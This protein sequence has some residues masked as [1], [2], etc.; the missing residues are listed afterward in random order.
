MGV[1]LYC[2]VMGNIAHN[3]GYIEHDDE[4]KTTKAGGYFPDRQAAFNNSGK[5]AS[6]YRPIRGWYAILRR[7]SLIR[8]LSHTFIRSLRSF[9]LLRLVIL[10]NALSHELRPH[11]K[12][13][14]TIP[15][16]THY[17]LHSPLR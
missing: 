11:G 3:Q 12:S 9:A 1:G 14:A 4:R 6:F 13:R 2:M 7:Y 15:L 10:D 16:T 17:R 5:I 8:L